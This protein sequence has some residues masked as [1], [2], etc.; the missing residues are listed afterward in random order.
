M[1]WV[2]SCIFKFLLFVCVCAHTRV[3]GHICWSEDIFVESVLSF[4]LHVGSG[5]QVRSLGFCGKCLSLLSYLSAPGS[6]IN[7][8]CYLIDFPGFYYFL[9]EKKELSLESVMMIRALSICGR[10]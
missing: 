8:V 9:Q 6:Y 5:I 10:C 4:Y 3:T 7:S 1:V 2:E